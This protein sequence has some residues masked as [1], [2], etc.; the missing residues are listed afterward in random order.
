MFASFVTQLSAAIEA[1]LPGRWAH[2][3][4]AHVGREILDKIPPPTVKKSAVLILLYPYEGLI[5]IVFIRRSA[6]EKGNHAGQIAF[7]GGGMEPFDSHLSQTALRETEEEVGIAKNHIS[8][9]GS[10][11]PIYIPISNYLTNPYVGVMHT[12]PIFLADKNEV[13]EVFTCSLNDLLHPDSKT[14]IRT[15]IKIVDKDLEI[16]CYKIEDK[17]IWGATAMMIAELEVI[18]ER[19]KK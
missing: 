9:I 19:I 6:T 13:D 17:I 11:T 8:L 2:K 7:P 18:M 4:M 12:P 16:P 1:G 5:K 10:L 14:T 15:Y 3:K